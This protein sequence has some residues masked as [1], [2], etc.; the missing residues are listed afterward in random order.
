LFL[1][2]CRA[3]FPITW[4]KLQDRVASS[5]TEE[6]YMCHFSAKCD[7][8]PQHRIET[9]HQVFQNIIHSQATKAST[10]KYVLT[11]EQVIPT[12]RIHTL[13]LNILEEYLIVT[14]L[15][16][17]SVP[18]GRKYEQNQTVTIQIHSHMEN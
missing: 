1:Y 3:E 4:E 14:R 7:A 11:K 2:T 17:I 12:K 18:T 5:A 9:S 8:F 6:T 13:Y 16:P 15:L 10:Y